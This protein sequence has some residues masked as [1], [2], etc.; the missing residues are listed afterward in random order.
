MPPGQSVF[1]RRT[2]DFGGQA[3]RMLIGKPEFSP[4]NVPM[5]HARMSVAVQEF[6]CA[7]TP[8]GVKP[9]AQAAAS[10]CLIEALRGVAEGEDDAE[11]SVFGLASPA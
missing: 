2:A 8:S 5:H 9:E 6:P 10:F 4:V 3:A 1:E 11:P 7:K